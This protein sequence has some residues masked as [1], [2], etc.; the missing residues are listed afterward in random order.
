VA[1][2]PE[3]LDAAVSPYSTGGGGTRLEHRLGTVFLARLLTAGPVVE[4][5]ELAPDRVAFQ[6]SPA[7]HVDDIVVTAPAPDGV[8]SVRLDIA[9]RRCPSF[10]RSHAKTRELVAALVRADLVAE[11]EADPLVDR[12]V[13]VAVSGPQTHAQELAGL[14]VIARG[15]SD[16]ERFV[17]LVR[18]PG[19]FKERRRLD[20]LVD[21]VAAGLSGLDDRS[22]GTPEHRTWCL[23]RRLW[24][25]QANLE[26]G[27]EDDWA[28]VAGDLQPLVRGQSLDQAVALRDRLEQL[29]ADLAIHAGSVDGPTLRRRLHGLLGAGSGA[30]TEGWTRLLALD[31]QARAMV[32]RSLAAGGPDGL[33]LP[34]RPVRDSLDAAVAEAAA[35][36][37]R[38]IVTGDSG[39]GKS[40]LVMDAIEPERLDAGTQALAVNLRHLPGTQLELLALLPGPLEILLEEL[41]APRRLLVIDAA[42]AAAEDHAEVFAYCL[43]AARVA[44]AAV[45]CVAATEGAAVARQLMRTDDGDL[46]EL[47]VPGLDDEEL[48]VAEARIPAL[49]RL[50]GEP[51]AREL[52]RR[53]I[54]VDLLARAGEPG[55]P[56]SESQALD[57][58]WRHLV[59]NNGRQDAGAPDAREDVM[60]RLAAHA[61]HNGDDD[62]LL[63]R[64]DHAAVEGLRRSG[65]LLPASG[66]PWERV[67]AFKHD[68]LRAYSVAR[69]LLAG[70]DPAAALRSAGAPRWALPSARL[71]CEILLSAPDSPSHRRAGRFSALQAE[72]DAIA[73]AS[74]ARWSDV[75]SEAL[76]LAPDAAA[77]LEDAWP[78]LTD[79]DA[80]GLAR[81]LRVLDVRHTRSGMADPNVAEPV[82]ARLVDVG[83]P[84]GIGEAAGELVR[85][86]LRA[87]VL[88]QTPAGQPTRVALCRAIV[89]RCADTERELDEQDAARRAE[90]AARTPEQIAADDERR[91]RFPSLSS[92]SGGRR[93][94]SRPA[95]RRSYLWISEEQIEHLALL[96]PDLGDEGEVILRRIAEDDPQSL[97]AAVEPLLTGQSLASRDPGLLADLAAAYYI[98]DDEDDDGIGWSGGLREDGIRD[99]K[100]GFGL[101]L[102]H[103]M[104][105]P[106]LALFRADYVRGVSLLNRM[107][108]HGARARV[109]ILAG[110]RDTAPR[111]DEAGT[112]LSISGDPRG[113]A[114][115]GQVWLWYRGT[116][117]GPY[118]CMSALQALE[119]VTEENVR[120]GVPAQML[121]AIMLENARSL[122]MPAL[123]LAVLVRHLETA[124]RVIDP[125]LVEPAVWQLEFSRVVGESSA[126]AAA[127]PGLT[128]PERRRWSLRE[129]STTLALHADEDRAAELRALGEQLLA[130]ARRQV[131][132]E[133]SA[134]ARAHLAAV[135]GWAASMD[136]DAYEVR[137]QD[138]QIVIQQVADPE[139]EQVLGPTNTD[140]GRTNDALG[141]VLR[142]GY[143]RDNGGRPPELTDEALAADLALARSLLADPPGSA[144]FTTDGPVAAAATAVELR[145]TGRGGCSDD[146]L[147]WSAQVLLEVAQNNAGRRP[148][149]YDDSFFSQGADRSAARALPLL[150]L[151]AASELRSALGLRGAEGVDSLVEASRAV[152]VNGA[153][154]ARLAY[155]RGLDDV[156]TEPCD[157][158]H[159]AGRCHHRVAFGL[160]TDSLL[161]SCLGPWDQQIQRRRVVQLDPPEL[162][163]LDAVDGGDIL[164][165]RLT[166]ALRAAGAAAATAACC[167]DDA[168]RALRPL[169]TAH[170][171]AMLAHEHG[172]HHSHSDSLVAARAAL[173]QAVDGNDE[174]A[175][176]YVRAYLP[177]PRMLA[178]GLQA[179][180]AAAEE[181]PAAAAHARRLWPAV[182]DLVL[183]AASV[184]TAVFTERTWGEYAEAAL[185]P[186]PVAEWEYL[187]HEAAGQP[188]PWRSLLA[189]APQVERWLTAV[190][191]DRPP[192]RMSIDHLVTA[193]RELD[194]ADQ[195]EQGLRWIERIVAGGGEQCASTFTLPEWLRERRPDLAPGEQIARWQRVVDLLVVAGDTRVAD[196]AD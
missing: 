129:V 29:S 86:W 123:A 88:K 163:A 126:L 185:V 16:S 143:V 182:M 81:L 140:L 15:Q 156:W 128:E 93:R 60:L 64:L 149:D 194:V 18:T 43:R 58:V 35:A 109:R 195:A 114:G 21:M 127:V 117:V 157:S 106:F 56:L 145:L 162:A 38:L 48:A 84:H 55:L 5:D 85:N 47:V 171:R 39:V 61:V 113:Y 92:V 52:L 122:A 36:G 160:V 25:I 133:S 82:V 71:A 78:A 166:P 120:A 57:H 94:R 10:V 12:R 178:E 191:G 51:R 45:V 24:I 68:L 46:R 67:P 31:E 141:L 99:H 73:A 134:G 91:R 142:H 59:R 161:Y 174:V 53:P 110:L 190:A 118:P 183:D 44:G 131:G 28:R 164:A 189:W 77:L 41:T 146:D 159:L 170:Q 124:D 119:F 105:G 33:R 102:S 6:Q 107:L 112:V 14:A 135:R 188:Q 27:H 3:Q 193:V 136:R 7:A 83:T 132:D 75:P 66:L 32:A 155:A 168:L 177:M 101:P 63:A 138:E 187:T 115:D 116:G 89:G 176:D 26:P 181:G 76:V 154:E 87:L 23:L 180:A 173:W 144:A 97:D 54:V 104:R 196:L 108:D 150:L 2:Q 167:K 137:Q 22:T 34:R 153:E 175:L 165:R 152:A 95:G 1:E 158:A 79:D 125:F 98:E 30:H 172:Y 40:A 151:P 130:N 4:L 90:L 62:E 20:H 65:V 69:L 9:V 37:G 17:E 184:D 96:G 13:A 80:A 148:D 49:S 11:Q 121:V 50:V 186:T 100:P 139:V 111:E 42:E 179:L 169:L 147:A 8:S 192:S 72:F 70:R 74:G 19:R 103:L